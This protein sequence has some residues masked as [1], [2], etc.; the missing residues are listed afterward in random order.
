M[1][2]LMRRTE[3]RTSA[4]L[5]QLET[6]GGA[7]GLGE[8]R[9]LEGD[10]AQGAEENVGEGGE[11]PTQLIAAHGRRR[12]AVG[13]QIELAFLDA[14]LHVAAGAIELLIEAPRVRLLFA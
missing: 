9:V 5:E 2:S 12:G 10:A 14:V 11:P 7:V 4:D 6:D 13:E 8:L 1:A 3:T